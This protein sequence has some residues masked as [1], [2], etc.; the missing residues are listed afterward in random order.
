MLLGAHTPVVLVARADDGL[1]PNPTKG[2]P[3]AWEGGAPIFTTAFTPLGRV[4]LYL[5]HKLNSKSILVAQSRKQPHVVVRIAKIK[6]LEKSS[7][8]QREMVVTRPS[9]SERL[10]NKDLRVT[11]PPL[12]LSLRCCDSPGWDGHYHIAVLT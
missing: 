1:H 9:R 11:A 6:R 10:Q 5:L 2:K 4:S 8:P 3:R 7:R 12:P